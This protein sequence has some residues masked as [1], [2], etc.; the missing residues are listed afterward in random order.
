MKK[1]LAETKL[2]VSFTEHDLR[3]KVGSDA[4]TDEDAQR[5]LDHASVQ[6]TRKVYRRKAVTMPVA[7]GF[8]IKNRED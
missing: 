2:S 1:A 8:K 7:K 5:Q 4:E 3:A 6:M